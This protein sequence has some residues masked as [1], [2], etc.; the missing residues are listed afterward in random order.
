[1]PPKK[2]RV[3]N[4]NREE[5]I[6]NLQRSTKA[7]VNTEAEVTQNMR[8]NERPR[9]TRTDPLDEAVA[10]LLDR[11]THAASRGA[12]RVEAKIEKLLEALDCTNSQK[13]RFVTFKLIGEVECW[14]RSTKAILDEMDTERNPITWE[15][16]K[17]VFYDNYL[18]EVIRERKEREFANLVQGSMTVEQLFW[19]G[20]GV[21]ASRRTRI[22]VKGSRMHALPKVILALRAKHLLWKGCQGYLAH[23]VDTRKDVLKLDDI[24]VVREFLDVFPEDL[25]RILI[26]REIEFSIDVFL[27]TSPISKAPY[28][29]LKIKNED[30]LKTTFRMRYG[31][32]EFL[33]MP[34]G[35]TNA[36]AAFM[37]LMNMVFHEYLDRFVDDILNFSKIMEEHEVYLRIIFQILREKKL[38]AKFKKIEFWLDQMVFLGH[39][40]SEAGISVDLSKVEAVVD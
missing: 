28:R 11:L 7:R 6:V 26:D 21:S 23:V 12:G 34:F 1:M 31:H 25:P 24:P 5:P 27:G 39:V 32:Y 20:G 13:V 9:V 35:F 33:V 22:S 10:R 17:W 37:D 3:A 15:K 8:D 18:F 38:H 14:W 4:S 40:I 2:K 29:M 36:P 30:I 16:F 19:K